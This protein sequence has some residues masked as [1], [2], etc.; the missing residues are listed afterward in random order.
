VGDY[1]LKEEYFRRGV[2]ALGVEPTVDVFANSTNHKCQR[3]LEGAV[4]LD[5]LRYAWA[6]ELPYA[7]LPVQLIPRV[8]Q[9]IRKERGAVVMVTPEWP[10]RPWLNLMVGAA[11]VMVRLGKAKEVLELG[12]SMAANRARLPPGS[13]IM[14]LL[15]FE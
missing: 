5:G 15:S 13:M 9:K 14:A 10:S 6:G 4:A 3:F 8:L 2:Q 7:F 12:P 11:E 1:S